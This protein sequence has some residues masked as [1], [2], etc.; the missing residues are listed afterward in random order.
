MHGRDVHRVLG[1]YLLGAS[2]TLT[3]AKMSLDVGKSL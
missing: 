3:Q 1:L 2:C